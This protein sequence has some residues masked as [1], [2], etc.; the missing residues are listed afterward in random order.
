MKTTLVY[1]KCLVLFIS[2]QSCSSSPEKK[3]EPSSFESMTDEL[4]T[5]FAKRETNGE[6]MQK[7]SDAIR[8]W[9]TS[10]V[11]EDQDRGFNERTKFES[12]I[13]RENETLREI[14][15]NYCSRGSDEWYYDDN[16]LFILRSSYDGPSPL[17]DAFQKKI[18]KHAGHLNFNSLILNDVPNFDVLLHH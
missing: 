2:F 10:G 17:D 18:L 4:Y 12:F 7:I 5:N 16:T 15:M 8:K 1:L 6:L 14:E 11:L 13:S 3:A 9:E